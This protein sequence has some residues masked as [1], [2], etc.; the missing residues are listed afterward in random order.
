M[1]HSFQKMQALAVTHPDWF[2][3][4]EDADA[5]V[6]GADQA[7]L[8]RLLAT[9]PCEFSR[10]VVFGKIAFRDQVANLSIRAQV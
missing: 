2:A 6:P 5:D 4:Y 7:T 8:E 9:A 1:I 10:G 3:Q